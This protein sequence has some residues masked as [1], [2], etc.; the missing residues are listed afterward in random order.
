MDHKSIFFSKIGCTSSQIK[1]WSPFLRK[2]NANILEKFNESVSVIIVGI[3]RVTPEQLK[4]SLRTTNNLLG[5]NIVSSEWV[6]QCIKSKAIIAINPFVI[7]SDTV[8]QPESHKMDREADI[9]NDLPMS[10]RAKAFC[11]QPPA[12]MQVG[13]I[14]NVAAYSI[15]TLVGHIS[16][17]FLVNLTV[18]FVF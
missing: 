11:S 16:R 5:V 15:G 10:K 3:P 6:V 14:H 1:I 8:T 2:H 17:S 4:A 13:T 7:A 18:I 12:C 9:D